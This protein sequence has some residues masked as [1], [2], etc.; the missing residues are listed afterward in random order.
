MGKSD[1]LG[2]FEQVV[3]LALIRLRANA[4]GTSIRQEIAE[5]TGRDVSVGAVYTTLERMQQKG[6]VSSARGAPT[7]ERGGR[8]KRYYKIEAPG[9]RALQRSRETMDR[10]WEGL[11]PAIS[12]G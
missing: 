3:L 5:R 1:S 8:A 11:V 4:Y 12:A 10:M 9:E 6:F 7:P 2:E